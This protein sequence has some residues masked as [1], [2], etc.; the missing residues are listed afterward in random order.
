MKKVYVAGALNS[1]ACGYIINCH[2]MIKTAKMLRN[3]GFAVYVPCNDFLE[4]LV[5]GDFQYKDYFD[6]SQPWLLSS[7]YVFLVP[8]WENSTGTKREIELAKANNIPVC[9]DIKEML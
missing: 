2:K 9:N 4:G 6:N 7:D 5:N 1:D 8:G 3:H